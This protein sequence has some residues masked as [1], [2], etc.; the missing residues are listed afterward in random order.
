MPYGGEDA[1]ALCGRLRQL[2]TQDGSGGGATAAKLIDDLK[3]RPAEEASVAATRLMQDEN[4]ADTIFAKLARKQIGHKDDVFCQWLY[5]WYLTGNEGAQLLVLR[6][7]PMLLFHYL[8]RLSHNDLPPAGVEA[9]LVGIYNFDALRPASQQ[10]PA[11]TFRM[12]SASLSSPFHAGPSGASAALETVTV[13]PPPQPIRE[14]NAANRP[15]VARLCLSKFTSVISRIPLS[16]RIHFCE[17][18]HRLLAT[19]YP[20]LGIRNAAL[21]DTLAKHPEC[22]AAAAARAPGGLTGVAQT[23]GG[24]GRLGHVKQTLKLG[25]SKRSI[26]VDPAVGA[27]A[28]GAYSSATSAAERMWGSDASAAGAGAGALTLSSSSADGAAT[29]TA[30]LSGLAFC[31][32]APQTRQAAQAAVDAAHGRAAY[33]LLPDVL[34]VSSSLLAMHGVQ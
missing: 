16:S 14:M 7:V 25:H 27:A 19:G 12:P 17:G 31:L 6:F 10:A 34:L 2:V 21:V 11:N 30:M 24:E 32:H 5:E 26:V 22:A 33:D 28:S 1:E 3:A 23:A 20:K 9:L 15:L 4:F 13:E 29:I 18:S 8:T